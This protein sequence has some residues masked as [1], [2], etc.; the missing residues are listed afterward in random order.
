MTH[1]GGVLG[2]FGYD[3]FQDE[4]SLFLANEQPVFSETSPLSKMAKRKKWTNWKGLGPRGGKVY[5]LNTFGYIKQQ[6]QGRGN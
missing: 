5:R 4:S 3:L 6:Q 2:F 1:F